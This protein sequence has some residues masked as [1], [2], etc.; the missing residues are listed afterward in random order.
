MQNYN[1]RKENFLKVF[2]IRQICK[3]EIVPNSSRK[4]TAL[5]ASVISRIIPQVGHE[6]SMLSIIIHLGTFKFIRA[7]WHGPELERWAITCHG[8]ALI[9]FAMNRFCICPSDTSR[10][11]S[12]RNSW[13]P[14][15][16]VY[17]KKLHL[18]EKFCAFKKISRAKKCLFF[19]FCIGR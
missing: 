6:S 15:F 11:S 1:K 14:R 2:C 3:F 9:W 17:Q 5:Y 12:L 8:H 4:Y 7:L 18:P 13:T 10:S 16:V 19:I